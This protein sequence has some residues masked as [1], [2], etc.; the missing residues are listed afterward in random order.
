MASLKGYFSS[1]AFG[2]QMLKEVRN[3][4]NDL[5][6]H[7]LHSAHIGRGSVSPQQQQVLPQ[8]GL[9]QGHHHDKL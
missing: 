4:D 3:L 2:V 5:Y 7:R 6:I 1:F 9:H 8:Q